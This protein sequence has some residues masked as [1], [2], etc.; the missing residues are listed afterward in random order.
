M[1]SG[2]R[3]D[4]FVLA[5]PRSLRPRRS[6]P[7]QDA[8]DRR[9]RPTPLLT[10]GTSTVRRSTP[11][12][13]AAGGTGSGSRPTSRPGPTS[14][15]PSPRPT[16]SPATTCPTPAT[17]ASRRRA[18]ATSCSRTRRVAGPT[19]GSPSPAT[20]ARR[21]CC[22]SVR[23]D[24]PRHGPADLL[25]SAYAEDPRARDFTERFLGLFGAFVDQVDDADR[26]PPRPA[27]RGRAARRRARL[28]GRHPRPRLRAGDACR[29]SARALIAAAPDLYRRR[30]TPQGL[31]DTLRI[32]LG[33][34]AVVEEP[35]TARP[36]GAVGTA[37]LGGVRLFGSVDGAGA[38]GQP[39]GSGAPAWWRGGNPDLDA[40]HAGAHRIRVL[41]RAPST[42]SGK[43][44]D[45][46]LVAR[47]ARS[48]T[49]A[50]IA[51]SVVTSSPGAR[52]GGQRV[53]I[54]TVLLGPD[55]AVVGGAVWAA[56]ARVASSRP[57]G[58]AVVGAQRA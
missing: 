56:A 37:R 30:G 55:P 18:S 22:T 20:A 48:Q 50:N 49:P 8:G 11:G 53:G 33:V 21:R 51:V 41:G 28:A 27:R 38:A 34:T 46:A 39:R 24:L 13:T 14:P 25:P 54:D 32:A 42:T 6:G 23:L 19:C 1:A 17:G 58:P 4:G 2:L 40:V 5:R 44:V 31:V 15:S 9:R 45:P 57:A 26:A 3:P 29:T 7:S 47:V 35:G 36:W 16:P 12:S 52:V 10:T 43:R